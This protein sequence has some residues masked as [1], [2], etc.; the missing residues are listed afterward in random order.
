MLMDVKVVFPGGKR[1][2]ALINGFT[3][4]TDQAV[5]GGGEGSAP[6]PFTLFL[7]SMATCAGIYVLAFCQNRGLSTEGIY[8]TMTNEIDP[9]KRLIGRVIINIIVPD[10]FPQKY[11]AP[12]IRSAEQ[13]AVAKH[14]EETLPVFAV[15]VLTHCEV[16]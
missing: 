9:D 2:D 11:H 15:D 12:L 10:A 4:E 8:L 7:A 16:E 5:Q 1:V 6:E 3:I 14:I 13:C